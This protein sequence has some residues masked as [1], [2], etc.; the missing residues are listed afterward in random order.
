MTLHESDLSGETALLH[1]L[2]DDAQAEI[3]RLRQSV[4]T[5]RARVGGAALQMLVAGQGK[6][7]TRA[8]DDDAGFD[9]YVQGDW[10]VGVEQFV[11]V[12]C[13]ISAQLP[14]GYWGMIVGRSSTLRSKGLLVA[15]GIIDGG[16]RGKLFAGVWNLTKDAVEVKDGERLAQL[17]PIAL[18]AR[19]MEPVLV[20]AL[21]KSRRG[22]AGFGSTGA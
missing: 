21:G 19:H 14:E 6:L 10:N 2:L 15:Q 8:Y 11:D 4:D 7:P 22:E 20:D 13:G 1:C 16:Y 17:I 12:E 5:L 18:D 9:L 3:R